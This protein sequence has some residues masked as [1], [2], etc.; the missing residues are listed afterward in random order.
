MAFD[1]AYN[2][3]L[4]TTQLPILRQM[5]EIMTPTLFSS[6]IYTAMSFDGGKPAS[7]AWL[8]DGTESEGFRPQGIMHPVGV[9]LIVCSE[10]LDGAPIEAVDVALVIDSSGS[11]EDND[12]S[13]F[14][15]GAARGFVTAMLRQ[16]RVSVVDFDDDARVP[17]PLRLNSCGGSV[18]ANEVISAAIDSSGGTAIYEGLN[19]AFV[20]L[21]SSPSD[22]PKAVILL[23]DGQ[24]DPPNYSESQYRDLAQQFA[25]RGWK[26]FTLGLGQN[27]HD[28]NERILRLIADTTGGEYSRL[29]KPTSL[30]SIYFKINTKVTEGTSL[31][32]EILNLL[33][34]ATKSI[35]LDIPA[36]QD[37][38]NVFVSWEGSTVDT[39]LTAPSGR[40]ITPEMA[41][42]D[43][44]IEHNKGATFELYQVL[45]PEAGDWEVEVFGADLPQGGEDVNV[46]VAVRGGA[47]ALNAF[48][49]APD[50]LACDQL[51]WQ[52]D[53][54]VVNNTNQDF[55]NG[56][57]TVAL[58]VGLTLAEGQVHTQSIANVEQ[59]KQSKIE[60]Q[61]LASDTVMTRTVSYT[62]TVAFTEGLTDTLVTASS[63]LLPQ[64]IR[65]AATLSVSANPV[66][67]TLTDTSTITL[68]LVDA[69]AIPLAN[70]EVMLSA[71]LGQSST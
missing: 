36:R 35:S 31:W 69:N 44:N 49:N 46:Q 55:R 16:D 8:V 65:T 5:T 70:A 9:G 39:T 18:R 45:N 29:I 17:W 54:I 28:I 6:P 38:V 20:Q 30:P 3:F 68:T 15:K 23:T 47:D 51:K 13:D 56:I 67:L 4:Y 50:T 7:M 10:K 12:P 63:I 1:S 25:E 60:W 32:N 62:T 41:A 11:M 58:P 42:Q 27:D 43:P 57:A 66:T 26:V 21:S 24:D 61:L 19:A 22:Q 37:L 53:T 14:R 52:A 34:N 64:C 71:T 48:I 33:Q 59:G 40:R 2:D